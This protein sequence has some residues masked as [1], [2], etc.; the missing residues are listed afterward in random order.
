MTGIPR[1]S[2]EENL[3]RI[4]RQKRLKFIVVEGA[5]DM[6]IY[7]Y[8]IRCITED[9][10]DFD[11]IYAGGKVA[12]Q[13]F[14]SANNNLTNC[15]FIVDK[16]FDDV[17]LEYENLV[18]LERYSIENYF[19]CN[20][21][22][23]SALAISLKCKV[24]DIKKLIS[25]SDFDDKNKNVLLKLLK[26]IVFYQRVIIPARQIGS[27]TPTWSDAFICNTEGWEVCPQRADSLIN[28][29]IPEGISQD[30]IDECFAS[31]FTE[32]FDMIKTFPGK[33]LKTSLHRFIRTK[34]QSI[35]NKSLNTKFA[36]F[37]TAYELLTA[38]LHKS[39]DLKNILL[40][41]K[42]FVE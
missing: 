37:D 4:S 30:D 42:N 32:D 29:L 5:H 35:G 7:D 21:V 25:I 33:M 14:L 28:Q 1:Y 36:N 2:A 9:S 39:P 26:A 15:L 18:Y 17:Y 20:E 8:V 6:P 22:I 11:V 3:R 31:C 34:I 40:P 27:F 16:D 12:I 41:V 38:H 24:S 13:E 10:A 19:F 23:A